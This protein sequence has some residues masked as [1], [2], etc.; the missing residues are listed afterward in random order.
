MQ[1][2][3]LVQRKCRCCF[4]VGGVFYANFCVVASGGGIF[5]DFVIIDG[6]G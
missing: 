4:I 2:Q 5:A 6:G 1:V 3:T